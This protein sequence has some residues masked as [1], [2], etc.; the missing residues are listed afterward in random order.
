MAKRFEARHTAGQNDQTCIIH[1]DS[2]DN[3]RRL[4]SAQSVWHG[5]P[6]LGLLK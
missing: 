2:V 6:F 4:S 5:K 3:A 1:C